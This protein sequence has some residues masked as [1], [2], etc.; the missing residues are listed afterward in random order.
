M[1]AEICDY[2]AFRVSPE[3]KLIK[4]KE[5]VYNESDN[6]LT[7]HFL[8]DES[9]TE[10]L[11]SLKPRLEQDFKEKIKK[12]IPDVD[13]QLEIFF[14]YKSSYMDSDRL[15]LLVR[16]FL[17]QNFSIMTLGL[18][19]DDIVVSLVDRSFNVDVHLPKQ[20]GEFVRASKALQNFIRQL[21]DD[22]FYG[23]NIK[24]TIK[25]TEEDTSS[26]ADIEKMLN[27]NLNDLNAKKVNKAL[28]I[29]N[30]EYYL[31]K[32]IKE[33]PVKI[34]FL[35]TCADEQV[36]AG[37]IS[38]LTKRD[39]K[40]KVTDDEGNVTEEQRFFWTFVI[41]DGSRKHNCVFFPNTNTFAKFEKLTDGTTIC[42][43]GVNN[44]RNGRVSFNVRGVSFCEMV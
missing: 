15:G 32:P 35:K 26:I 37:T 2:L 34:E 17:T 8:F 38:F 13:R 33:R 18:G 9:L 36:T 3:Y 42:V 7:L 4:F 29:K 1:I 21:Y 39:F 31:G 40:K 5:C 11:L 30:M 44:E 14:D 10:E 12:E 19:D 23:F 16:T 6:K 22:Y 25:E 28:A 41:D 43:I 24:V 27:D 20:A